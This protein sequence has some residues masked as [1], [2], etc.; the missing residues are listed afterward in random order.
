MCGLIFHN[1]LGNATENYKENNQF[2]WNYYL[3]SFD[4]A[5]LAGK[6]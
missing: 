3:P 6:T 2:I 1:L 5:K 4:Q